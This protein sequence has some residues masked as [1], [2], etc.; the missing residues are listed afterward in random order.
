MN[1]LGAS[2]VLALVVALSLGGCSQVKEEGKDKAPAPVR[3]EQVV[4]KRV[5]DASSEIRDAIGLEGKARPWNA[6]PVKC[7]G[8]PSEENVVNMNHTWT[9]SGVS[10]ESL[11]EAMGRLRK[12]LPAGGWKIVKD[13]PDRSQSKAPQI[14]ANS[15]DGQVSADIRLFLE[16]PGAERSSS[17]TIFVVSKCFRDGA[18]GD[19]ADAS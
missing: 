5:L 6:F 2:I 15:G 14:V 12:A 17:I 9:F 10:D 3:D 1:R 8:Y 13:G 16:P 11:E 7:S 4:E 18:A 19:A